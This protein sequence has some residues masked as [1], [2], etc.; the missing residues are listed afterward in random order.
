MLSLRDT[1]HDHVSPYI[2]LDDA[3]TYD[4]DDEHIFDDDL[5][6][7][8]S[9]PHLRRRPAEGRCAG[10]NRSRRFDL[11]PRQRLEHVNLGLLA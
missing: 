10:R 8:R 4:L 2:D 6:S 1:D 11:Q 9:T 7:A 5:H 3:C